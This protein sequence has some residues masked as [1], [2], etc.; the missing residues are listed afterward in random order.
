M[1]PGGAPLGKP[2]CESR[3]KG[4]PLD[5]Q[6]WEPLFWKQ[7]TR[8]QR[9]APLSA[10]FKIC[11][12]VFCPSLAR[13][14]FFFYYFILRRVWGFPR[15]FLTAV[16][17]TAKCATEAKINV[18]LEKLEKVRWR[19]A[20]RE[21]EGEDWP[22]RS[23]QGRLSMTAGETELVARC[24]LT[25]SCCCFSNHHHQRG[26]VGRERVGRRRDGGEYDRAKESGAREGKYQ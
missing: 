22:V 14:F 21:R 24:A 7:Q 20:R 12:D 15:C 10:H 9:E 13:L 6:H 1:P 5:S 18:R 26:K 16:W 17:V 25:F 4:R 8:P 3:H 19:R 11:K 23:V 2:L